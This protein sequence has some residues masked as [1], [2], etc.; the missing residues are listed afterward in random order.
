ME[1]A[2]ASCDSS[3]SRRAFKASWIMSYASAAERQPERR[4]GRSGRVEDGARQLGRIASIDRVVC[5]RYPSAH[6]PTVVSLYGG[7]SVVHWR[8]DWKPVRT[9]PGSTIVQ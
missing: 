5:R 7:V 8:F 1:R 4:L 2:N 3:L 6:L 9:P